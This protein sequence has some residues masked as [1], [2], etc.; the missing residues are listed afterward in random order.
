MSWSLVAICKIGREF[1]W[2]T[3]KRDKEVTSGVEKI[4]CG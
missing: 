4:F 2:I 1:D 3:H